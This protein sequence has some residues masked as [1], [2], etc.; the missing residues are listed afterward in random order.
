LAEKKAVLLR[1]Y[2]ILQLLLQQFSIVLCY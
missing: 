2:G 1:F